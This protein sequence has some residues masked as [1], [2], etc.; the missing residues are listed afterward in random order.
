MAK[1]IPSDDRLPI[2]EWTRG[3]ELE[4]LQRGVGGYI[5]VIPTK[6]EGVLM[7]LNEEGK[8]L[9]LRKNERATEMC[10]LYGWDTGIV[11]NVI[12]MT[13]EELDG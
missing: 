3:T 2:E 7:V 9:G 13:E 6:K 4:Y 10:N 5:E 12:I 11:G 8:L 1:W